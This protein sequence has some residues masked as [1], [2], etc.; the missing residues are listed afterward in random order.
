MLSDILRD[1]VA[2][3]NAG[4][5]VKDHKPIQIPASMIDFDALAEIAEFRRHEFT[6][7]Y[8]E[9]RQSSTF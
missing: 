4:V 6:R 9:W 5:A 8:L 2:C 3:L 1:L 7:A